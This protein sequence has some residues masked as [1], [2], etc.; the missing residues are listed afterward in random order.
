MSA[1]LALVP[2]V[3]AGEFDAALDSD[4][5][6]YTPQLDVEAQT[7]C[8]LLWASPEVARSVVDVLT[9]GDFYRPVY[10]ELLWNLVCQHLR[11]PR[12]DVGA[13]R[14]AVLAERGAKKW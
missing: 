8:A 12:I 10:G 13:V 5:V 11:A 1:A 7:L 6:N 2:E 14:L 9:A 3:V 4:D